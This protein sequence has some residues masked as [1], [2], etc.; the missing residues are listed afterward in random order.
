MSSAVG[1]TPCEP[2]SRADLVA[3]LFAE[4]STPHASQKEPHTMSTATYAPETTEP[5]RDT[6]A[7]LG[8]GVR[9]TF[10]GVVKSERIKLTSLRSF[11][12]TLL[13]TLLAGVGL[14]F[15]GGM[16]MTST[17]SYMEIDTATMSAAELQG[18]LLNVAT[19]SSPFLALIFGVLGV[20]AISSEYSS[21]MILSSLA[22]VPRRTPMY[23]AK[24]L[25]LAFVSG[26]TAIVLAVASLSIAV[27]YLPESAAEL[28]SEVVVSGVF[29]MVAYLLLIA[30]LGYG[31]AAMLRS[32]AGGIAIVAGLTFVLPIGF[33]FLSMTSWEWVPVVYNY[34]PMPLG[35]VLS[36]GDV[37]VET[38][39]TFYIALL[40]MA[41]WALVP[42]LLG[43]L[44]MKARDAK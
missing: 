16:A 3:L 5:Q 28:G 18:Y 41:I 10:G 25:V 7:G 6:F 23:A 8:P 40:A 38:G 4:H 22:A 32:T 1:S 34:L 43:Q 15:L 36:A 21:G 17:Y 26:I 14:A 44:I 29:G 13:I 27:L 20:F 33:Q 30:L 9:L 12:I 39:P 37:A 35:I 24:A 2:R 19:S 31:I 11:R 42:C